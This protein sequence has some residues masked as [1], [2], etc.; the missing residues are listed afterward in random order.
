M[1][2]LL[3]MFSL[4]TLG[5]GVFLI[6]FGAP[7]PRD[8]VRLGAARVRDRRP[9]R[10]LHP[11]RAR[12]RGAG[13]AAGGPWRSQDAPSAAA[14]RAKGGRAAPAVAAPWYPTARALTRRSRRRPASTSPPGTTNTGATARYEPTT[15][16]PP[17]PFVANLA[18]KRS[19][20]LRR[21][22]GDRDR[23]GC[24]APSPKSSKFRASR[25][26]PS[27]SNPIPPIHGITTNRVAMGPVIFRSAGPPGTRALS[28]AGELAAAAGR[29]AA[30]DR[31]RRLRARA[32]YADPSA[33]AAGG[34]T[35]ADAAPRVCTGAA[36]RL[37]DAPTD[38][39]RSPARAAAAAMIASPSR[40]LIF[41]RARGC[42][43][44]R[45]SSRRHATSMKPSRRLILARAHGCRRHPSS[46]RRRLTSAN[47]S[48]CRIRGCGRGFRRRPSP[49]RLRSVSPNHL[50]SLPRCRPTS[51][52]RCGPASGGGR[53]TLSRSLS[54]SRHLP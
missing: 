45:N 51:S 48:R 28:D 3:L 53:R 14:R 17:R 13:V 25:R 44:P 33:H 27:P 35:R 32:G 19:P 12:G 8:G 50:A 15:A 6:G 49:S 30:A 40:S 26:R 4:V 16:S 21:R 42:R 38:A 54:L 47:L 29:S 24:A 5:A 52:T 31:A 20:T 10:H 7:D 23:H 1:F 22:R 11:D 9:R 2:Y 46:N 43:R 39:A 41:A 37:S 18:R 34:T 36:A